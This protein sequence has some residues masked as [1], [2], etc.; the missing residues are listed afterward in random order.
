MA[1]D[2]T[3]AGWR[4]LSRFGLGSSPST[5]QPPDGIREA[6]LAETRRPLPQPAQLP[7]PGTAEIGP[8]LAAL[9]EEERIARAAAPGAAMP[10]PSGP[11][12]PQ[13]ILMEEVTARTTLARTAATGFGER[14]VQ[15]WSNHLCIS[16]AKSN[17]C[18][19]MAGAYERE[20]VRPHVFGRFADMLRASARHPAML[21]FL[22]NRLSVGPESPAGRRRRRGL[23]ENLARE[24]LELHT[25]GVSGG[26]A[27]ADVT[28]LARIITGWG[29]AGREGKVAPANTFAFDAGAQEPGAWAVL[30]RNYDQDGLSRGGAVLDDLARH[31]ATARFLAGKLVRHFPAH[32]PPAGL[33]SALARVYLRSDG[34]LGAVSRALVESDVA[35][36]APATK[37]RM[38]QEFLLA[39]FRA[40][41]LEPNFGQIAGPLNAMGQPFWQPSGPNGYAD[42]V[43]SWATPEGLRTR[44]DV[45]ATLGR[46]AAGR[47][48]DP[49][50]LVET[51]LGPLASAQTRQAVARAESRPQA[52]ALLL[53]APEFQRR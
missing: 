20:V 32:P 10:A 49:R 44:I 8:A 25:L 43:A 48:A 42:T 19:A 26:Y 23:N 51:V 45:A 46:Q 21:D 52:L 50:A 11:G 47:I 39:T 28:N 16:V 29:I 2:A 37:I 12:L 5:P 18:R 34:D 27:Q 4:A 15:F 24:I 14:L 31:P 38:P 41:G 36:E 9:Q 40:L 17:L 3:L 33:V 6:L 53:M 7:Y 1:T 30:G 35:W 22:D 13:R